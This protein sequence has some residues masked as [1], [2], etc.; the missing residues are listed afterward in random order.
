MV[1]REVEVLGTQAGKVK[2][3]V[4]GPCRGCGGCRGRC[5]LFDLI[6]GQ[7]GCLPSAQFPE[8]PLPGQRWR[9]AIPESALLAAASWGY[10]LPLL[11]LLGGAALAHALAPLLA[12]GVDFAT[13]AGAVLGTSLAL[14][15]SKRIA[16]APELELHPCRAGAASPS[17]R[18]D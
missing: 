2:L 9:L 8:Q 16:P 10:G 7:G 6:E 13:L 17:A 3:R 1:E 14:R 5:G 15:L 12:L 4:L 11:G 18:D